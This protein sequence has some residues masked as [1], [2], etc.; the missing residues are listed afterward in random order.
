MIAHSNVEVT[1]SLHQEWVSYH[2]SAHLH[3]DQP[4]DVRSVHLVEDPSGVG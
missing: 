4:L 3:P 2:T 1:S